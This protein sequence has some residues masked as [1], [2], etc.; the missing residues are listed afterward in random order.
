MEDAKRER[1]T[2]EKNSV[3]CARGSASSGGRRNE[4][5]GRCFAWYRFKRVPCHEKQK[6]SL[7]DDAFADRWFFGLRVANTSVKI[8]IDL[9]ERLG[10]YLPHDS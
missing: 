1:K 4:R 2:M 6:K 8:S 7:I 5:V 10:L 3:R 9:D